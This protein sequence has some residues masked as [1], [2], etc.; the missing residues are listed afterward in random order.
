[1][2]QSAVA[3]V[4]LKNCCRPKAELMPA[5]LPV[6]AASA[7]YGRGIA[8]QLT[9]VFLFAIMGILVK[10]LGDSYPTSQIIFFRSL[11]ALL[12]LF[13]YLPAQ[14]GWRALLTRRPDLQFVR[15]SIGVASMFAGFYALSQMDFATY[16]TISFSAPLFGTLLA[17]PFLGEK[18]GFK[19]LA[20]VLTGFAGVALAAAPDGS[21]ISL[22]A[23]LALAA[24]FAYGSI[25]VVMRKLGSVDRSAATVFYFTL[26]GVVVGGTIMLFEWVTPTF[27]DLALLIGVGII[28]GVAQMFMTEAFRQAPTSVIAPF[29]YTAMLWAATLGYLVFGNI[30][31]N[32]VIAGASIICCAGL[33]ILYR[34]TKLGLKKP[35]LKRSSL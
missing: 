9:A 14:G 8:C 33:F 5:A 11:P 24:A 12:P 4:A 32:Q 21:G 26:A 34:E 27:V 16:V 6:V 29:D 19:R 18:V 7:G 28:G 17:I 10:G 13:L 23:L 22:Y 20:A 3:G 2:P 35:K 30:P 25:M 31:S 1:M 15:A